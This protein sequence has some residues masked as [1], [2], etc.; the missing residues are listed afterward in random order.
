MPKP[1]IFWASAYQ[2]RLL[3]YRVLP[4]SAPF[5]K[6]LS[7]HFDLLLLHCL[8]SRHTSARPRQSASAPAPC[9]ASPH[10]LLASSP[11]QTAVPC[12]FE[13]AFLSAGR[14]AYS[15]FLPRALSVSGDIPLLSPFVSWQLSSSRGDPQTRISIRLLGSQIHLR[16]RLP[17]DR[18][19]R[20]R[21]HSSLHHFHHRFRSPYIRTRRPSHLRSLQSSTAELARVRLRVCMSHHT[22]SLLDCHL[23]RRAS[24]LC[25]I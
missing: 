9:A 21:F 7:F 18:I 4:H 19:L 16:V 17:T 25:P 3:P 15:L 13:Q 20:P 10:A 8:Y 2:Q 6:S 14:L 22:F 11:F 24:L 5:G 12:R 1:L 23:C